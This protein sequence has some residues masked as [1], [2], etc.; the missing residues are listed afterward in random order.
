VPRG[1]KTLLPPWGP[2]MEAHVS[3]LACCWG[4][5]VVMEDWAFCE[6][7]RNTSQEATN[8]DHYAGRPVPSSGEEQT[9]TGK[10]LKSA[11]W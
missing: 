9:L 11:P 1:G 7:M 5:V 3:H 4:L 2:G 8:T 10:I 6:A